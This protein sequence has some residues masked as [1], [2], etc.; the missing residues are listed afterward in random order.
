MRSAAT[1]LVIFL[2]ASNR[3]QMSVRKGISIFSIAGVTCRHKIIHGVD[4]VSSALSVR[5]T[6]VVYF[7]QPSNQYRR[8]IRFAVTLTPVPLW[9]VLHVHGNP[10]VATAQTNVAAAGSSPPG[11]MFSSRRIVARMSSSK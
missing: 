2:R 11:V 3:Y 10:P 5:C 7:M 4:S 9:P 1:H 6:Q 8:I